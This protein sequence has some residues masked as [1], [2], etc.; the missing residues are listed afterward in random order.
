MSAEKL[1]STGDLAKRLDVSRQAIY[2]W[3]KQGLPTEI[4]FN[5]TIRYDWNVVV[6][7]LNSQGKGSKVG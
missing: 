3:R 6:E 1:L 2:L 4:I 7:W 5:R